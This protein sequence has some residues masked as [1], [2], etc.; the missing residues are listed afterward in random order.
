MPDASLYSVYQNFESSSPVI[1]D[2]AKVGQM[3]SRVMRGAPHLIV[4][5]P[6]API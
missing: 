2:R 1:S 3:P 4:S 5:I 6:L